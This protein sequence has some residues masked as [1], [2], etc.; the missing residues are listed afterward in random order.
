MR[1]HRDIQ[2]QLR[3]KS[4]I[5]HACFALWEVIDSQRDGKL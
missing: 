4:E 2:V 5:T 1:K 3:D